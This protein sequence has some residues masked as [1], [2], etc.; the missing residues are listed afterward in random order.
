MKKTEFKIIL[1]FLLFCSL[2]KFIEL[3]AIPAYIIMAAKYYKEYDSL[4]PIMI[5]AFFITLSYLGYYYLFG[6]I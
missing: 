4:I 3:L 5:I 1:A 2:I 6:I